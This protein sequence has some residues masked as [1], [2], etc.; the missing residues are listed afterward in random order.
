MVDS[1][2]FINS[3]A[4]K[5]DKVEFE[6]KSKTDEDETGIEIKDKIKFKVGAKG[7]KSLKVKVSYKQ[8]IETETEETETETEYEIVFD[9]IIEYRKAASTVA[10]AR[11][12]INEEVAD[13]NTQAY[14]WGGE[15]EIV[16]EYAMET[17][18]DFSGVV[19]DELLSTSTFSV[20]TQDGIAHFF[21]TIAR[22][23]TGEVSANKMKINFELF[24]FPWAANDT[25]VALLC[26][27]ESTQEV[28]VEYEDDDDDDEEAAGS[29]IATETRGGLLT[30]RKT[31][32]VKISFEDATSTLNFVPIGDYSWKTT[33]EARSVNSSGTTFIDVDSSTANTTDEMEGAD[34]IQV[35]A[36]SPLANAANANEIAFS[37][38][39][40]A[41]RTAQD[42]YWDPEAG[43]EYLSTSGSWIASTLFVASSVSVSMFA[44]MF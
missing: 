42:I 22:A 17:W 6:C 2:R 31:K 4:E 23:S 33:A 32:D 16:Q 8:E 21:F 43:V 40:E 13:P 28:E 14:D 26:K 19:A 44:L 29:G 35:I 15:D 25:Y 37:F 36:T 1:S 12:A 11:Q 41:A 7:E 3:T 34:N 10:I 9:K 20:S 5:D 39:G 27:I 30:S 18:N 38:V 24:G